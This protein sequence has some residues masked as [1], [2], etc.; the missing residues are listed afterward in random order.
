[1][2]QMAPTYVKRP[3][4]QSQWSSGQQT[5]K[6]HRASRRQSPENIGYEEPQQAYPTASRDDVG[7]A[8]K[9]SL[10]P[11]EE[12]F[13]SCLACPCDRA[14]AFTPP[15]SR[16]R[17]GQISAPHAAFALGARPPGSFVFEA[18]SRSILITARSL[19]ISPR[20]TLSMGFKVSVSP[21]PCHPSYGASD[22]LPLQV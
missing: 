20:E 14:V 2:I 13:S 6:P 16:C 12:G 10:K 3:I 1:M 15:R 8:G 11:Y 19:A 7:F 22:F 18:T 21:P 9:H 5:G 17:V 4:M